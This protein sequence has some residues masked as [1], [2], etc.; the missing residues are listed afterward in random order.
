NTVINFLIVAFVLFLLVRQ[1]NR[2][3]ARPAAP[4]TPT[5]KQC[6]YCFTDIPIKATRC[7]HCTSG[8]A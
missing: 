4:V 6:P 3:T 5:T 1:V 7:P 8:L 2:W